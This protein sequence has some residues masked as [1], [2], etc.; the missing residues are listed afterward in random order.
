MC[1]LGEAYQVR[2]AD[3]KVQCKGCGTRFVSGISPTENNE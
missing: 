1:G 3:G 2:Q